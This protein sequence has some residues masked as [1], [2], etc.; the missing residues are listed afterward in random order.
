MPLTHIE[1]GSLASSGVMN[2]N[3]EYLDDRI[4]NVANNLVSGSAAIY[5]SISS[6]SSSFEE[7]TDALASDISD[8]ST[9]LEELTGSFESHN[10]APDYDK[11]ITI[12]LPYTAENNG[13]I[14]AGVN[15]I[16]AMR[17]VYVNGKP[18]HGHCGYSGGYSVYSGSVFR[19]STDDIVTCDSNMGSYYFY[20]MKGEC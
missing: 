16:D 6:L 4:T 10:S 20:P 19:V 14:Y 15:G 13:Y 17:Y 9:D 3:F 18:V 2:D 1:Y 8:L 12:T 7:Q 11:G 5:S